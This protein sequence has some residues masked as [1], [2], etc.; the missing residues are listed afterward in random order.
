MILI[1]IKFSSHSPVQSHREPA[2][3]VISA[4]DIPGDND[5]ERKLVKCFMDMMF[6][7]I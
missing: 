3:A 1:I 4:P 7:I 2:T 5:S 6:D